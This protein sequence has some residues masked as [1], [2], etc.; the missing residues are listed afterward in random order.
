MAMRVQHQQKRRRRWIVIVVVLVALVWGLNYFMI[1]R[2]IAAAL[3]ADPR[4]AGIALSAHLR[5][6]VDPTT[7]SIDLGQ[8]QAADTADVFRA[9]AMAADALVDRSWG[10][11]GT[12]TLSHG[13]NLVYTIAGDDLRQHAHDLLI[14]RRPAQVLV[15]IVQALSGADG[16]PLG[17]ETTVESAARRWATGHP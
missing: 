16:K 2:P 3:A 14:S 9:L 10:L 5:F 17:P 1:S 7:L 11:P 8:V 12:L 4:T 6:F 13:G 15:A